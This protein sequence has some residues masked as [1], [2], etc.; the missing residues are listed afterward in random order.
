M[1]T[2]PKSMPSATLPCP[3]CSTPLIL[4]EE[5]AGM[6]VYCPG[7]RGRLRLPETV[8]PSAKPSVLH[9]NEHPPTSPVD[10]RKHLPSGKPKS[11]DEEL[12]RL[13]AAAGAAGSPHHFELESLPLPSDHRKTILPTK[14]NVQDADSPA[15]P[16]SRADASPTANSPAGT[17]GAS[18]PASLPTR[19][20]QAEPGTQPAKPLAPIEAKPDVDFQLTPLK[21]PSRFARGEAPPPPVTPPPPAEPASQQE[22]ESGEPS[23]G[24]PVIRGGFRLGANRDPL[25]TAAEVIPAEVDAPNWGAKAESVKE[26]P[27]ARGWMSVAFLLVLLAAGGAGFYMLR[28]AFQPPP[29]VPVAAAGS[30]AAN[31]NVMRNVEDSRR[32]IQRILASTT[33]EQIAAEV[34]HPEI[35][36]PRMKQFY[37]SEPV[38]PRKIRTENQSWSELRL[39]E[40]EFI[41]GAIELDDFRVYTMNFEL[42]ENGDP[43]LDWESFVNWAELPWKDFLKAP[44]ED[45]HT[46]RVTVTYDLRDQYYNY[47]FQGKEKTMLCFKLEDPSKYG[48]CW[49]Y[50]DKSTETAAKLIFHLKRARQ[51]GSRNEEKKIALA[52]MLKLRFPPEGMKTNQVMIEE[53]VHDSWLQP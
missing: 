18:T 26:S 13:A 28:Q 2:A 39:G 53:F 9:D 20:K 19:R 48:S 52:C 15:K 22:E 47:S 49:A 23:A 1:R 7:C 30:D 40:H 50:C 3:I 14:R 27:R 34:R 45:A 6:E 43:K 33:V 17:K 12:K 4:D 24:A 25:F 35:T 46:F 10:S 32:V 11:T 51:Q 44:P 21:G 8:D 36:V 29:V 31:A 16:G 5:N 41:R 37:A 42:F 38:R